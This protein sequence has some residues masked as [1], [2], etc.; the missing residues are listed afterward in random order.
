MWLYVLWSCCCNTSTRI[1]GPKKV[2][3]G[4]GCRKLH[5]EE[6]HN[7]YPPP[8]MIRMV[9]SMRM[10]GRTCRTHGEKVNAYRIFGGKARLKGTTKKI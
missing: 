2:E 9:K 7:L 8:N 5:N 6:L 4:G 1:F 3:L 10:M